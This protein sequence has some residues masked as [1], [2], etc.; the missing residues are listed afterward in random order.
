MILSFLVPPLY[1]Y[2]N[3]VLDANYQQELMDDFK[4]LKA[5]ITDPL[6]NQFCGDI[7]DCLFNFTSFREGSVIATFLTTIA[8]GSVSNCDVVQSLLSKMSS[9]PATIGGINV[10]PGSVTGK[11]KL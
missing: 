6:R 11:S 10:T 1:A 5:K 2:G 3:V 8:V 4:S 9:I 7:S